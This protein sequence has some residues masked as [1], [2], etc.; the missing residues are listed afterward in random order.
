MPVG[1]INRDMNFLQNIILIIIVMARKNKKSAIINYVFC[2][3]K[4]VTNSIL[5]SCVRS[6][7]FTPDNKHMFVG[8]SNSWEENDISNNAVMVFSINGGT[9]A[10]VKSFKGHNE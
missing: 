10:L 1:I 8:C 2:L 3:N 5:S 7:V 9:I 4:K 6:A